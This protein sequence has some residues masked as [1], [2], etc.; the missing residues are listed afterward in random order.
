M[1]TRDSCSQ[2]GDASEADS[3]HTSGG[4]S[5]CAPQSPSDRCH[6]LGFVDT[7]EV[8]H[9]EAVC[10]VS[11]SYLI[12]E[13]AGRR[14][15]LTTSMVLA[16]SDLEFEVKK[17]FGDS[18]TVAEFNMLRSR[19]A[20]ELDAFVQQLGLHGGAF[21]AKGGPATRRNHRILF[22][23]CH[24]R[25]HASFKILL[26]TRTGKPW[27]TGM[28]QGGMRLDLCSTKTGSVRLPVLVDIGDIGVAPSSQTVEPNLKE[29]AMVNASELL[30]SQ[31]QTRAATISL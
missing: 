29:S 19:P 11:S 25:T 1:A 12:A 6:Q 7:C 24:S 27:Q 20:A 23:C 17:E 26:S 14:F 15:T 2:G 16:G 8:Y 28:F 30:A 9:P 13:L 18:A 3:R 5:A 21:V 10:E 4:W 31:I 22:I